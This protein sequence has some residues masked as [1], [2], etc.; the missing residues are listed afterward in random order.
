MVEKISSISRSP[1]TTKV[2]KDSGERERETAVI[3]RGDDPD[4]GPWVCDG[5]I[6]TRI[7][8]EQHCMG[9]S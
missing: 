3:G 8:M 1:V 6:H 5:L 7:A 9:G 4:I 2:G